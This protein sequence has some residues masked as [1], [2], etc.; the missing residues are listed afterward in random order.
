MNSNKWVFD[1][2]V[3]K[4]F[5]QEAL[6]NIPDY[7]KTI[8]LT[9][10]LIKDTF[11]DWEDAH[12]LDIGSALGFTVKELLNDG[13]IEVYGLEK[14]PDM[15]SMSDCKERIILSDN[16]ENLFKYNVIIANW[17]L[18]FIQEREEFIQ[19]IY[20]HL[21]RDGLF[22]LSEKMDSDDATKQHYID[23]KIERG[24]TKEEIAIKNSRLEN[25]LTTKPLSWYLEILHK[26]GFTH[27]EII[28]SR[29]M[30]K[31]II[32]RK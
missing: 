26:V 8:N 21:H 12:I 20:D 22:I 25:V 27:I 29:L 11:D 19:S 17:T 28:N 13:F 30:F 7:I 3:A 10:Q 24:M 23:F 1:L 14:S 31:T 18:H 9:K 2:E 15:V 4:R 5:K 32:C 6:N 16:L